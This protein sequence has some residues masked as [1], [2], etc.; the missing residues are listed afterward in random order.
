M[1]GSKG[2]GLSASQGGLSAQREVDASDILGDDDPSLLPVSNIDKETQSCGDKGMKKV[3]NPSLGCLSGPNVA[4]SH[5][6]GTW[7]HFTLS[8]L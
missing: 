6:L 7:M 5:N 8:D 1:Q 2:K 3:S 4:S